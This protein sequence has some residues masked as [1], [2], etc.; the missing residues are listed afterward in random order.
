MAWPGSRRLNVPMDHIP[1]M[2]RRNCCCGTRHDRPCPARIRIKGCNGILLSGA[3]VE[4]FTDSGLGTLID[5]GTTDDSGE[6]IL[7]VP[8]AGTWWVQV[9]RDR[10]ATYGGGQNFLCEIIDPAVIEIELTA[11]DRFH[12]ICG[13]AI[14]I[15]ESVGFTDSTVGSLTLSY[16][17]GTLGWIGTA[18]Y[19]FPGCPYPGGF[20]PAAATVQVWY[21]LFETAAGADP[22]CHLRVEAELFAGC[23]TAAADGGTRQ[24]NGDWALTVTDCPDSAY[25][26]IGT[27]LSGGIYCGVPSAGTL[28]VTAP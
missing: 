7:G 23:P 19:N 17:A 10:F 18:T 26:A 5:E 9:S 13:C 16:D 25:G 1:D 11:G 15:G 4:I 14:P 8:H 27:T 21:T 20:C 28:A 12:C 3:N 22:P 6:V 24:N 2:L